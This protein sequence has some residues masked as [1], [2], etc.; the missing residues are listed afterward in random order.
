MLHF[1]QA[2]RLLMLLV[3]G[4]HSESQE[5]ADCLIHSSPFMWAMTNEAKLFEEKVGSFAI[6][7]NV[8]CTNKPYQS[9]TALMVNQKFSVS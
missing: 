3:H 9:F 4:P 1:G 6:N 5:D 2:S 7:T 8:P